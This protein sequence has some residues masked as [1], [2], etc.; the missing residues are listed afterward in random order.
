MEFEFSPRT[1]IICAVLAVLMVRA[2]IWQWHR[3]LFKQQYIQSLGDRLREP[4]VDIASV[5]GALSSDPDA[6]IHRRVLVSGEFDFAHEVVLRNRRYEEMPGA[7][8]VTPLKINGTENYVLVNRGFIPLMSVAPE[9]RKAFQRVVET[10]TNKAHFIG[11]LKASSPRRFLGPWD[12]PAGGSNPWVDAWLWFDVEKMQS[13]LPYKVLPLSLEI[14]DVADPQAAQDRI[15]SKTSGRD[16]MFFLPSRGSEEGT[17]Q[18]PQTVKRLDYPVPVFDTVV[19]PGR[20]LGYVYEWA[21]MAL[22]TVLIGVVLQLKRPK[23]AAMTQ[24]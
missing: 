10:G 15:I 7:F 11:L 17:V 4:P 2:S 24:S 6:F 12:P 8:A 16:D 1:T 18:S 22:G 9:K 13:Q 5:I 21:F 20:H 3:H 14:M 23:P 19:P